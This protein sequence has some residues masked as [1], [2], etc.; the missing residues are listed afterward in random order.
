MPRVPS[1]AFP[2]TEVTSTKAFKSS[3]W[4]ILVVEIQPIVPYELFICCYIFA[5]EKCKMIV[6][7]VWALNLN[8]NFK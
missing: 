1:K 4:M 3:K 5:G 8:R 6:V 7:M 2:S